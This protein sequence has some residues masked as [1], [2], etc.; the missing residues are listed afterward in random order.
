MEILDNYTPPEEDEMKD[1]IKR[2]LEL[3]NNT[4]LLRV[5]LINRSNLLYNT[6]DHKGIIVI[7]MMDADFHNIYEMVKDCSEFFTQYPAI[8]KINEDVPLMIS[9]A[10]P[11]TYCKLVEDNIHGHTYDKYDKYNPKKECIIHI[12]IK[13]SL[14]DTVYGYTHKLTSQLSDCGV[15][16][17]SP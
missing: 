3:I 7:A 11:F 1:N 6:L 17:R 15:V 8:H 13:S 5:Y 4:K 12:C 2:L 16:F 14:S 10:I 9:R